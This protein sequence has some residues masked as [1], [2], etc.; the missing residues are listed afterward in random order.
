MIKA[1]FILLTLVMALAVYAV[2][3]YASRTVYT[4]EENR[5][6]F[7][8]RMALRIGVWLVYVA[9][10][11]FT[12]LLKDAGLPPRIPLLLVAPVFAFA[13]YF[14]CA[15]KYRPH[16]AAMPASWLVYLQSFR[17]FV[18]LLL[19]GL[20]LQGVLPKSVT[21]EGYN[22]EMYIGVTAL[23]V[24]LLGYTYK[25]LPKAVIVLWHIAGLCTLATIVILFMSHIYFPERWDDMNQFSLSDFGSFPYTYLAGF[26]MPL[27]VFLHVISLIKMRRAN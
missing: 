27:A 3:N 15:Q 2:L 12:G 8:V 19:W 22:H 10:I 4:T 16:I 21:F 26:L 17:I 7:L 5:R 25:V 1:G 20:F 18:E 11:S 6:R 24:G 13:I 9:A 14:C 23:L